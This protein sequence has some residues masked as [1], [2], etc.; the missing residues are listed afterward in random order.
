MH[1]KGLECFCF[2]RQLFFCLLDVWEEAV[3]RG[4]LLTGSVNQTQVRL[5]SSGSHGGPRRNEEQWASAL[6]NLGPLANEVGAL[7]SGD[8][9]L[10]VDLELR[11][12]V[13]VGVDELRNLGDR[14]HA[15]A[16]LNRTE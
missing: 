12:A 5:E 1:P 8:E 13:L 4:E 2:L 7:E 6:L 9:R 10:V 16:K 15:A 14:P 3:L 11:R